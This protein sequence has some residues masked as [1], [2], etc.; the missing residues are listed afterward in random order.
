[1]LKIPQSSVTA[2]TTP[3]STWNGAGNTRNASR[4]NNDGRANGYHCY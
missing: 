3:R 4:N 2:K 1:M